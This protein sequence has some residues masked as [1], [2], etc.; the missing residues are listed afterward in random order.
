MKSIEKDPLKIFDE[1]AIQ[2]LREASLVVGWTEDAGRLGARVIDY[3]GKKL[4]ALEFAQID[5][6]EFFPLSGVVVEDD[7]V[8][9][10]ETR[11]YVCP[12]KGLLFFKGHS[13]RTEWYRFLNAILDIGELCHI[14]ELYTMGGMV[15]LSTHT[16]SRDLL[17][18]AN[19]PETKAI[20]QEYNIASD[21]S[22]ETP[23]NQRPTLSSYLLW[24]AKK[25]NVPGISLWVPTPFYLVSVEDP[26]A[27]KKA[28]EFF[29]SR[30]SLGI[31]LADLDEAISKQ[32]QR[33][34][35]LTT[36][37]PEIEHYI[38]KLERNLALTEEENQKLVREMEEHL[39]GSQ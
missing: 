5:L 9:F 30:F 16:A 18:V 11:F 10:P 25:R 7:I 36:R 33:I 17:A 38:W 12:E 14:R 20:L 32:N 28:A 19:S 29:N 22:Y 24:V 8:Q 23:P 1:S 27:W 21:M 3:L 39:K 34:G 2:G 6:P 13:P 15:S 37:T 35:E 4:G 31:D 26:Q